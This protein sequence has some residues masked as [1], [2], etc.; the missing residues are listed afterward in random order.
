MTTLPEYEKYCGRL[1]V[2][3]K[4]S[5]QNMIRLATSV[6]KNCEVGQILPDRFDN[7][8]FP[9]YDFVKLSWNEL[10]RVIDERRLESSPSEPKRRLPN[11][12]HFKW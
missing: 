10:S 2:K 5:S 9:G 6:M 3:Y 11:Y 8:I 7:D 4:N 12:R 1:I